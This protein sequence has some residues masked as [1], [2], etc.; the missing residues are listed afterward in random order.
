VTTPPGAGPD[1]APASRPASRRLHQVKQFA[2][3]LGFA[4]AVGGIASGERVVVWAAIVC[5]AV[6]FLLR[7]WLRRQ[8]DAA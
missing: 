3:L 7:S 5:L 2:A 4:L 6:S 1:A 8:N